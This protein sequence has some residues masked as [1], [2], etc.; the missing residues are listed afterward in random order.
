MAAWEI[1]NR[2]YEHHFPERKVAGIGRTYPHGSVHEQPRFVDSYCARQEQKQ[3]W[4]PLTLGS[5]LIYLCIVAACGGLW[6]W[7]WTAFLN[8]VR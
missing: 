7:A 8:W 2:V 6:Y 3:K 5:I 4:H 1:A